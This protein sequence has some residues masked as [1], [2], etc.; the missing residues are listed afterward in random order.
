M[1]QLMQVAG[2]QRSA[3]YGER[4]PATIVTSLSACLAQIYRREGL[5]GLYKGATLSIVKAAPASGVTLTVYEFVSARL[6]ALAA[7]RQTA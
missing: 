3:A 2:L 1:C 6:I 5:R 4:I 7:E